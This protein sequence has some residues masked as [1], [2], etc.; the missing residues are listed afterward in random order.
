AFRVSTRNRRRTGEERHA[1][2][3]GAGQN[4][5]TQGSANADRSVER[6]DN[7]DSAS[8]AHARTDAHEGTR[9]ETG[10]GAGSH[11]ERSADDRN[12]HPDEANTIRSA[13]DE[14]VSNVTTSAEGV[15]HERRGGP[16]M[17]VL[18]SSEE[19]AASSRSSALSRSAGVRSARRNATFEE[20]GPPPPPPPPP[21]AGDGSAR[22]SGVT[23][24]RN[25][26]V[27]LTWAVR[28]ISSSS[29]R[30]SARN[31]DADRDGDNSDENDR[32]T[33][34]QS[35]GRNSSQHLRDAAAGEEDTHSSVNKTSQQLA[36]SFSVITRLIVDLM[37]MLVDHREYSKSSY[38][39]IPKMLEL[40]D[41]IVA[42]LR[43]EIEE[44]LC[45]TW[46][47][48]ESVLDRTE[49]QLRF[50]NALMWSPAGA[51]IVS[52]ERKSTSRKD[53]ERR[54][55]R[56]PGSAIYSP[57][58]RPEYTTAAHCS[59]GGR[60]SGSKKSEDENHE[61][62][63]R[64]DF[65]GYV[66]SLMRS[67]A[68]EN[69][70]DVPIIEFNA[71]KAL[72]FIA[73]AYLSFVDMVEKVDSILAQGNT[74]QCTA[75]TPPQFIDMF[76]DEQMD[77]DNRTSPNVTTVRHFFQRSNSLLY[78]G[79]TAA[80]NHHAFEHRCCDSLA[81]AER[82]QILKPGVEKEQMFGLPIE[83]R[84]T[85][86]HEQSARE[87]GA[88]YPA[89]QGL[90]APWTTFKDF[91]PPTSAVKSET[92]EAVAP[93]RPNVIVHA[94]S[95]SGETTGAVPH[96]TRRRTS[97]CASAA[98]SIPPPRGFAPIK[99]E[100]LMSALHEK[101]QSR[102]HRSL[103][104]WKHT[105][106]LMAKAYHEQLMNGCGEESASSVLLTEMAGFSIREAQFRKRME[107]FKAAQTK[108]LIF[109]VERDKQELIAQTIR[110]LNMHYSRRTANNNS[111]GSQSNTSSGSLSAGRESGIVGRGGVRLV[112]LGSFW[113]GSSLQGATT[114]ECNNPPL[115][116]HK[117][118]VTF[119]DE[120]GE[121]TGV[122]RSFYSAVADAFLT[123]QSL[124]D[125]HH[126]LTAFGTASSSESTPQ[127][128]SRGP[129]TRS[130]MRE[131]SAVLLG[132]LTISSRRR[133]LRNRY[134]L[135]VNSQPYFSLQQPQLNETPA[136][137][138]DVGRHV[139]SNVDG[140]AP[141]ARWEPDRETL[142][143]RLL[144]R[145]RAIRPAL[146]NKITGML[147]DLQPHQLITILASEDLLRSHVEEAA[148]MLMAAGLGN[149]SRP[150]DAAASASSGDQSDPASAAE[151]FI[152][153]A[154]S[155]P[156]LQGNADDDTA[157]LFYR[158]SKGGYYTPIAGKNTPH[159]LNAF[160]NVGRM[161][162][163]CLMQMEI[164]P[165]HVCRHVLKFIL[166]RPIN[167]FDLAFYDP[168]L[169]ESM[170]T[171]VFDDGPLRPDQINDLLLTFEV[172]LPIEEGGGM[173]ELK[174]GGSKMA[175]THENVVEYI[176]RFV[177]A[178]MLGNH[179]KC[180]EAIKQ[181]VYDVIP[182]GSLANMTSE[183]LR[184]LLCGTQEVS[185][186]LMQSYT[187]FT[188]ESSAAP[189]V[190][191]RFKGWFWSVCSKFSGQEKQVSMTLMQSYTTFTDE[192]SAAPDVLQRFKGWFWSVCSKFSGQEKQDLIFFW[193]GSP[194]LPSS[195]EGFQPL[196]TVLVR[197]ADD[198]HLPTANTCISRLYLPLYSSKK[199]LR[200]K[201]LLAIKAKNFGFV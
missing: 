160:R 158:A 90:A 109:E 68:G 100:S 201:L 65:F 93:G 72:A 7:V 124:P 146:C 108:D 166:G 112:N 83:Q 170:R 200:A 42:A 61:A 80:A 12:G 18:F 54:R 126:V 85:Q 153:K 181:G 40:S 134:T 95:V 103:A 36:M 35:N 58:S 148:E 86:D 175:V 17:R 14:E 97:S 182:A 51:L 110:Q 137:G 47:W 39:H 81:L 6:D 194:S 96:K 31:R 192:S 60:D 43:R 13:E 151:S 154:A 133:G 180:L 168:V 173:V 21:S 119:K 15:A 179:L 152:A 129:W 165:L 196:P 71:L 107:K 102:L 105:L 87:H 117:V 91:M 82:P 142:G 26:T 193:T 77:S 37:P 199:V 53:E 144:A 159:R 10:G 138:A 113:N 118:K 55:C 127:P 76:D 4:R 98:P 116:C 136:D 125:E 172:S 185:M 121:G 101:N 62:V 27:P 75:G 140:L 188:D 135:S 169:F 79:I 157:P 171:L 28:R 174:R 163:I 104:R 99:L 128:S 143:E 59:S 66:L 164:F 20:D 46:R 122:A 115:A 74:D 11:P 162:G 9:Q 145:V 32:F 114:A 3:A 189:D 69:G 149:N 67:S 155:T 50:G 106:N 19:D 38:S 56:R 130:T 123:M 184:L 191:Q 89:H 141:L 178:R 16:P 2:T 5:S 23:S 176:Y 147:L 195:E 41:S 111:N 30:E 156:N 24:G 78:P 131:R 52:N 1:I 198:Q 63:S 25:N 187:T 29:R 8:G 33:D 161:I 48:M 64:S 92:R 84:S 94:K 120:P 88:Q 186:T 190:L 139:A 73:D 57:V 70:D 45:P 183:D 44:R 34:S 22:T 177:E 132:N 49:A 197:P 167:W 150:G